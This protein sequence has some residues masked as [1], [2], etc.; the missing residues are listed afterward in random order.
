VYCNAATDNKATF[1]QLNCWFLKFARFKK[2]DFNTESMRCRFRLWGENEKLNSAVFVRYTEWDLDSSCIILRHRRVRLYFGKTTR[3]DQNCLNPGK[4]KH[5]SSK[6][7]NSKKSRRSPF[8]IERWTRVHF[9]G[10]TLVFENFHMLEFLK[11]LCR[12]FRFAQL[13]KGKKFR[14]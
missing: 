13:A 4:Y 9:R 6:S 10:N 3:N 5:K 2:N 8:K 12:W 14:P 7:S 1:V 11:L